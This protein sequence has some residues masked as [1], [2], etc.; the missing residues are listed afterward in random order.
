MKGIYGINLKQSRL[1]CGYGLALA[2]AFLLGGCSG[3]TA[4]DVVVDTLDS[5]V[6]HISADESFKP[7]IDSQIGV[8]ESQHPKAKIFVHYKPEAECIKDYYN[9]SIRMVITTRSYT[10]AERDRIEDSL[11]LVLRRIVLARDAIAVIL[12][13][14]AKDSL[15]TMEEVREVL[16]GQ[17]EKNLFP[18]FDGL[19]ATGTYRFIADSVLKGDT[20]TPKVQAGKTSEQVIEFVSRTPGAAGFIGV[21]WIGNKDDLEQMSFLNKVK[22]ARIESKDKPDSYIQPVQ[23]NIYYNRYPMIR[24]I[25]CV[26]KEKHRGGLGKGFMNFMAAEPGQLIFKRAYLMPAEM[27]FILREASVR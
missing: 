23:A 5:G 14:T 6:I 26:L 9:D 3:G 17:T 15:M 8:F 22:V 2:F 16:T 27:H 1:F 20:L 21:S 12:H 19:A 18:V 7:V 10:D 24:N 25:V 13:P 11:R 4:A